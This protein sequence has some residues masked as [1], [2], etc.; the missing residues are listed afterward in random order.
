M[1]GNRVL[2]FSSVFREDR[3]RLF[4]TVFLND[5]R[6]KWPHPDFQLAPTEPKPTLP[7]RTIPDDKLRFHM[8]VA[9]EKGTSI[10]YSHLQS[11]PGT[12]R[13]RLYVSLCFLFSLSTVACRLLTKWYNNIQLR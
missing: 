3:V 7:A 11:H 2:R 6:P 4:S 8:A 9:M 13:V 10:F 5:Y 1:L 12:L